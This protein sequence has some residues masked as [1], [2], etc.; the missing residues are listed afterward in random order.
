MAKSQM[1]CSYFISR[2]TPT[3]F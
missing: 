1:T 2:D 3:K